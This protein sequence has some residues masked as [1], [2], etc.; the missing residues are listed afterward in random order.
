M[1]PPV[2]CQHHIEGGNVCDMSMSVIVARF[3]K[4]RAMGYNQLASEKECRDA[5]GVPLHLEGSAT[6]T[7]EFPDKSKLFLHKG[8]YNPEFGF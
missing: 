7:Y 5:G 3:I 1:F 8:H 4:R 6:K 2:Q